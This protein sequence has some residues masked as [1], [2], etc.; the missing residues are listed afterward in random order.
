MARDP[1]SSNNETPKLSGL[2]ASAA[3]VAA[4]FRNMVKQIA[5]SHCSEPFTDGAVDWSDAWREG[6]RDTMLEFDA[7]ERDG[8]CKISCEHCDKRSWI[9]Y[10]A[11]TA[12][13]ARE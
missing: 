4:A 3:E 11:G 6:R 5:C 9:N 1:Q 12:S 10:F 7:Q 13:T 8:P 2:S